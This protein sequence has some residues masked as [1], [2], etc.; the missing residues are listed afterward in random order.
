MPQQLA[1]TIKAFTGIHKIFGEAVPQG[2]GRGMDACLLAQFAEQ[3]SDGFCADALVILGDEERRRSIPSQ[4][5]LF[6]LGQPDSQYAAHIG[7]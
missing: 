7:I 3:I 4:T 2:M 6:S 5:I 1:Y